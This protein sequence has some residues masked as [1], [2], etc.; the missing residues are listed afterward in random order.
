[1]NNKMDKLN[2]ENASKVNGGY[3]RK[4]NKGINNFIDDK[5]NTYSIYCDFCNKKIE[6]KGAMEVPG[7]R[8]ACIN[9]YKKLSQINKD[10]DKI[11]YIN[12]KLI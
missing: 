4:I 6:G 1:M 9:C 7:E 12:D 10:I 8:Q 11:P 5:N 2:E 3:H